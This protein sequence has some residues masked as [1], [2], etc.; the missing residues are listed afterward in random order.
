[1]KKL[2]VAA[3]VAAMLVFPACGV[4]D[5]GVVGDPGGVASPTVRGQAVANATCAPCHGAALNG[6]SFDGTPTP[7]L[8]LVRQY[9]WEQLDKL[10]STG[11][12]LDGHR[13]NTAMMTSS[14]SSLS[15]DDRRALHD[16]LVYYWTP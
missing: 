3:G 12:T 2:I 9:T 16:Y 11:T 5:S 6:A 8:V 13:V 1:M 10:L 7:S 14:V 4:D 15:T